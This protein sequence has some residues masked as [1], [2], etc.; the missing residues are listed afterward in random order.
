[1][2]LLHSD[3]GSLRARLE[4]PGSRHAPHELTKIVMVQNVDKLGYEHACFLRPRAH[5]QFVAKITHGREPHA[6]NSQVFTKRGDVFHVE[7]VQRDD[8]VDL[9]GTRDVADGVDQALQWKPLRHGEDII[10]A[11]E[12]PLGMAEFFDGQKQDVAPDSLASADELLSFFVGADAKD[13][14]RPA[15]LHSTPPENGKTRAGIIQRLPRRIQEL[16]ERTDALRPGRFVVLRALY[17]LVM[18]VLPELPAFFEKHITKFF[19]VAHDAGA[20]TRA[21]VKSVEWSGVH[22]GHLSKTVNDK[23]VPPHGR[24]ERGNLAKN[25]RMFEPEIEGDQAA[26][27]RAT[28]A[29]I[30]RTGE[31]AVFAIDERLHFFQQELGIAV[32][33]AATEFGHAGR[34]VFADARFGVVHADDDERLD[35]ARMDALIRSLTDVPVL[36]W[37]E[38]RGTIEKILSVMKIEDGKTAQRLLRVSRR[39]VNDKV[40]L[41]AKEARAKL[42]VFAELSGTHGTMVTKRSF[43]STCWPGVTCSFTMRPAIGA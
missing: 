19:D 6:G 24:R 14:E 20:F 36:S 32:G 9:P 18:Q 17:A 8:T 15:F 27:R 22:R 11:F 29:I 12:W 7:F 39:R 1:M 31:R 34:S 26:Q 3:A 28:D 10:E 21:D 25:A 37:N 4:Q 42:F 30:L 40:P 2:N 35:L 5:C 16:Q 23:L 33:S 41:I 13:G 43:A 38:R